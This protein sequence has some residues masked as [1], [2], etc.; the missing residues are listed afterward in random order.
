MLFF[1]RLIAAVGPGSARRTGSDGAPPYR[2]ARIAGALGTPSSIWYADTHQIVD[3]RPADE[4]G[5]DPS[6]GRSDSKIQSPRPRPER[7]AVDYRLRL[8]EDF[9]VGVRNG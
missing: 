7:I 9:W 3:N 1:R 2:D 4:Q 8:S 5:A 6:V